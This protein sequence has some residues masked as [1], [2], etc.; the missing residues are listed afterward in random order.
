MRKEPRQSFELKIVEVVRECAQLVDS[1][2]SGFLSVLL[3]II[4]FLSYYFFFSLFLILFLFLLFLFS[5]SNAKNP[6]VTTFKYSRVV[7]AGLIFFEYKR[8]SAE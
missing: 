2:V 5:L 4:L 3:I 7:T 1:L 8:I 6:T